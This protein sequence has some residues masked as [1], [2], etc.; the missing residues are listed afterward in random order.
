MSPH[1]HHEGLTQTEMAGNQ[2]FTSQCDI[3]RRKEIIIHHILYLHD[4]LN[5]LP[6]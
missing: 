3:L 6:C 5:M 4:K 1:C 2:I